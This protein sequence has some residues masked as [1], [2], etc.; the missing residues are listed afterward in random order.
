MCCFEV[1]LLS[2]GFFK[3]TYLREF[4]TN[5]LSLSSTP[6]FTQRSGRPATCCQTWWLISWFWILYK[7]LRNESWVMTLEKIMYIETKSDKKLSDR[8]EIVV[9][10][11]ILVVH[12]DSWYCK[13]PVRMDNDTATYS[14]SSMLLVGVLRNQFEKPKNNWIH[15]DEKNLTSKILKL[16]QLN[17]TNQYWAN[18]LIVLV[19]G[20][21]CWWE[22]G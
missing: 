1:D 14:S 4:P 22:N 13:F 19:F 8:R 17:T 16:R 9:K 3:K 12:I 2:K 20:C 15:L 18:D 21:L 11:I 10:W 6:G 7:L 5:L